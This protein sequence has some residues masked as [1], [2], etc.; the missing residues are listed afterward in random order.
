MPV[1]GNI[2]IEFGGSS[3]CCG[4]S[5]CAGIAITRRG[6]M[7]MVNST[8]GFIVR[9]G[10][11]NTPAMSRIFC[12]CPRRSFFV[13]RICLASIAKGGLS[14]GCVTPLCAASS[15]RFLP[16][17]TGGHLL[18]IPFSGS[19]F[20]ACNSLP[21]SRSGSAST[22]RSPK[23]LTHSAVSFRIASVFGKS[24]RTNLILNSMRRSA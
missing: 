12:M 22:M 16:R 20:V 8:H 4:D 1:L 7:S 24:A 15:G 14:A 9:C 23:P 21:L 11:R 5:R 19:N 2:S 13:A 3:I 10:G 18:F 6:M 17:D